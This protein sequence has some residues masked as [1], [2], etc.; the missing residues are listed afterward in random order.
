MSAISGVSGA[1]GYGMASIADP[2]GDMGKEEFMQLLIAQLQNQDPL[3][4]VTNEDFVAQLATF[5]NL[6]QL[7]DI[8][9]GTQTG[10]MMQQSI[11]NELASSLIGKD[12]LV[13][14]SMLYVETGEGMDFRAD[15][16][17]DGIITAN[18][19][20]EQGDLMRTVVYEG[21]DGLP[22]TAGEHMLTWDGRNDDGLPV[23]SGNYSVE[24]TALD[25]SGA[26]V[27]VDST[28]RGHVRGVRFSG[29]NA[30][31]VVGD[32]E[33]T[34]AD[35]MEILEAATVTEGEAETESGGGEAT[36][37]WQDAILG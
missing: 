13:D 17:A 15:L 32:Q 14:C 25:A 4:P 2:G 33:F 35:V 18:I 26:T 7:T 20:N 36:D 10:L 37:R 19:Y 24:L 11:A 5:S 21:E 12:V 9:A 16:E 3:E 1:T 31:L 34:L 28:M 8:N 23:T 27:A 22:L 30:Y 29:G 6:E